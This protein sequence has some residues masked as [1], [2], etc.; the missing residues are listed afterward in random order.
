MILKPYGLRCII[1][2][3][4]IYCG[5]IYRHPNGDLERFIEHGSSTADRINQENKTCIILGDFNIDLLKLN[6]TEQLMVSL[7]F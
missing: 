5:K 7:F 1:I 6:H 3:I 2:L 4:Q